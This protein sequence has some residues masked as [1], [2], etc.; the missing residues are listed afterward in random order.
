ME[1]GG[2]GV[3]SVAIMARRPFEKKIENLR[4]IFGQIVAVWLCQLIGTG[5]SLSEALILTP[6]N[7]QYDNRLFIE[8][9]QV[10]YML[11]LSIWWC[12]QL[13]VFL[14]WTFNS[15]DNSLS[16]FGLI[17]ARMSAAKKE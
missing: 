14:Y 1:T 13:V 3:G 10:Q 16:Y 12:K 2:G 11:F 8:L 7:P 17:D 6:T 15:M 4:K 5:K 9:L